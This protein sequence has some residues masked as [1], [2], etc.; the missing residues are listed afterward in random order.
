M[1]RA[2]TK[3]RGKARREIRMAEILRVI[4]LVGTTAC[5]MLRGGASSSLPNCP[6]DWRDSDLIHDGGLSR[7]VAMS[8]DS[9][10]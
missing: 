3:P 2:D 9:I 10:G 8:V 4:A 1:A 5:V 6:Q 7:S